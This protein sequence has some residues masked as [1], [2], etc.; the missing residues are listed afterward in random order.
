M[1]AQPVS[2]GQEPQGLP[3]V[4]RGPV[5]IRRKPFLKLA[6]EILDHGGPGYLQF[7]IT[8]VCN[9]RCDF[10][11]FARNRFD[12]C[13]RRSVSLEEARRVIAICGRNHIGYLLFVGGEPLLHKDLGEMIRCA[14]GQGIRPMVCTNGSLWTETNMRELADSGLSSVIMSVDAHDARRHE[15]HRGLPEVCGKI[16]RANQVFA[17]LGVPTTASV[18]ASRLIE[19]YEAL[20]GFLRG[21]GFARC[22]FS[23]PLTGLA[24]S[25]LGF[26]D[27]ALVSYQTEEL[28]EVF[29]KIRALRRGGGIGVLNPAESL[30]EMQRHLRREP[31]RFGCLGGHKYFYADWNLR[32]YRCHAWEEPM[33]PIE[34]WGPGKLIRDGCTRCMIDCYRDAS[35]LQ[36][37]A[38]SAMDA[39]RDLKAGRPAAAARHILDTRNLASL[40][41]VWEGR[42][43]VREAR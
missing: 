26:R 31:E 39:W 32:L 2:A 38:I 6:G 16:R 1:T 11:G 19:D 20:P 25:Y 37:A 41:A 21:L 15:E 17:A 22:S 27:C 3:A 14:A 9:A 35:V 5:V 24:S 29:E 42:Q 30:A 8:N 4:P 40:R 33:C 13:Q 18:T 12:A 10:C 28:I 23:Y 43:W 36:F 7:A 34:Q